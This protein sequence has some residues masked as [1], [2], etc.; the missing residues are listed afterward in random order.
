M[1]RSPVSAQED[2]L[3]H[4]VKKTL[5]DDEQRIRSNAH[6]YRYGF[7]KLNVFGK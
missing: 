3:E 1:V 5:R 2:P 6:P 4:C 7:D